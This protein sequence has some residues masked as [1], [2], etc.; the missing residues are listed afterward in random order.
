MSVAADLMK[1]DEDPLRNG[2]NPKVA[3]V[4]PPYLPSLTQSAGGLDAAV[5]AVAGDRGN[6]APGRPSTGGAP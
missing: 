2:R 4:A 6:V 3:E 1:A 5:A